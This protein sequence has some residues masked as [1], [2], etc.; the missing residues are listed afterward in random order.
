[1][2]K[3][4]LD[5]LLDLPWHVISEDQLDINHAHTVLDEDHYDLQE[6]KDRIVE[7]LAVRKL[8]RERGLETKPVEEEK[9]GEAT[10]PFRVSWARPG[11]AKPVWGRV[12]PGPWDASSPA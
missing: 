1:V 6:V 11:S 7:F 3:T 10:G 4:Y 8:V 2:I 12:L 9:A 5:W